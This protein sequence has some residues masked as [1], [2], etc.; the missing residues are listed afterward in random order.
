MPLIGS[1]SNRH[2]EAHRSRNRPL[3]WTKTVAGAITNG[4][5]RLHPVRTFP[6]QV[7]LSGTDTMARPSYQN[8][9]NSSFYAV[10]D[11]EHLL[12]IRGA[13]DPGFVHIRVAYWVVD[14]S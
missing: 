12:S 1:R 4:G 11:S 3:L 5:T 8:A 13:G 14:A 6:I 9:P 7:N 2:H 10:N